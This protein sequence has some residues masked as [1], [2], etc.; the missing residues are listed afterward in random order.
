MFT[1]LLS[2]SLATIAGCA[3][4]PPTLVIHDADGALGLERD[5]VLDWSTT[6]GTA[7]LSPP[8]THAFPELFSLRFDAEDGD[9]HTIGVAGG[10]VEVVPGSTC[11]VSRPVTCADGACQAELEVHN[12]GTCLLRVRATTGDGAAIATCWFRALDEGV[13]AEAEARFARLTQASTAMM[14]ACIAGL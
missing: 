13:G 10:Q 2:L 4:A 11:R 12:L 9:A 1:A 5:P 7:S 6:G 8:G 14:D 3:D